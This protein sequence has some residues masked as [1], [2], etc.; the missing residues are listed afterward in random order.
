[1]VNKFI[2]ILKEIRGPTMQQSSFHRATMLS[3]QVQIFINNQAKQRDQQLT[4]LMH[5]VIN[6]VS[7][8]QN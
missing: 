6:Q 2:F 5:N 7:H 1:M 4:E 8:A 3:E